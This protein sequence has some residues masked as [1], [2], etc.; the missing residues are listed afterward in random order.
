MKVAIGYIQTYD[1]KGRLVIINKGEMIPKVLEDKL[2][3]DMIMDEAD[4]KSRKS[5]KS[6]DNIKKPSMESSNDD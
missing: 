3:S 5:S 2:P 1:G 6:K 4:Y